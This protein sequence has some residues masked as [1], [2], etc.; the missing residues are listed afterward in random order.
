M[1]KYLTLALCSPMQKLSTRKKCFL[2]VKRNVFKR[3]IK[4]WSLEKNKGRKLVF[5]RAVCYLSCKIS[6]A[7][8][9]WEDLCFITTCSRLNIC[10]N[11]EWSH[12]G[13]TLLDIKVSLVD[14]WNSFPSP[15]RTMQYFPLTA[16]LF[17][18]VGILQ[19]T[20]KRTTT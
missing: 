3:F 15:G 19:L 6:F 14:S 20:R 4:K 18:S 13:I 1:Q 2:H 8:K 9:I 5:S 12:K 11:Y 7:F 16:L 10:I 17:E